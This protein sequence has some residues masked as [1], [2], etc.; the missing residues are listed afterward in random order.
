MR[1]LLTSLSLT[2]CIF[3][4]TQDTIRINN[5]NYSSLFSISKKYPIVVDWWVTKE[6]V[7]CKN[8]I[9]RKNVFFPDPKIIKSSDLELSYKKS[10]FDRGHMSPAADNQCQTKEILRESFYY[11][12]ISPQYH[13]LNAGE[14]KKLEVYTRELSKKHDSIHVWSGNLGEIKKIGEVSVPEYCWKVLFIKKTN[15]WLFF[16]FKNSKEKLGS[17][18]KLKVTKEYFKKYTQLELTN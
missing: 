3:G 16:I 1:L 2:I 13:S 6:K 7:S 18:E 4:F 11:T 10:G 17:F 9:P 5:T 12:N 8:P 14:W 15:E